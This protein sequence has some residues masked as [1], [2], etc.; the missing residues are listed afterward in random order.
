MALLVAIIVTVCCV[1][2]I[3]HSPNLI[4]SIE[5]DESHR[6]EWDQYMT[7]P[8]GWTHEPGCRCRTCRN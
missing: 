1:A 6:D 8:L 5:P 4:E 2:A 3:L 7:D